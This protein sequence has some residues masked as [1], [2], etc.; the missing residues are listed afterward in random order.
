[1]VGTTNNIEDLTE[2]ERLAATAPTSYQDN[3]AQE[4]CLAQQERCRPRTRVFDL[5]PLKPT[6]MDLRLTVCVVL[7]GSLDTPETIKEAAKLDC[8]PSMLEGSSVESAEE[9]KM[10]EIGVQ[11]R[12]NVESWL[13]QHHPTFA[14]TFIT[15]NR[16]IKHLS[17]ISR[18][19]ML[20]VDTTLPRFRLCAGDEEPRPRQGEYPVW[21][22]FYG[23][24]CAL[25]IFVARLGD[26]SPEE[27]KMGL[28]K[29]GVK[30]AGSHAGGT[31]RRLL[32][33]RRMSL[34]RGTGI[35]YGAGRMKRRC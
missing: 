35:W 1:M 26:I 15:I 24:L 28:Q 33:V 20:G 30:E 9:V 25:D 19:P 18:A 22:F 12:R 11:G 5:Q 17:P 23:T 21:Y 8:E 2:A 6:T 4:L 3:R 27:V 7:S 32:M 14:P 10:C 16:A 31:I 13:N 34:C 29:A